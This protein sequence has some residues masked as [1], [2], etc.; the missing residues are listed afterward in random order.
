MICVRMCERKELERK[1]EINE[2]NICLD[3]KSLYVHTQ[4][5]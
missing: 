3:A 2:F 5:Q 4:Y 1:I